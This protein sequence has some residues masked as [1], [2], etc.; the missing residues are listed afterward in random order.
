MRINY[1][2]HLQRKPKEDL[3]SPERQREY[4][5]LLKKIEAQTEK[6]EKM[7]AALLPSRSETHELYAVVAFESTIFQ[8]I[9]EIQKEAAEIE[10][11]IQEL[12][13]PQERELMRL[14]YIDGMTWED[15]SDELELSRQWTVVL[16]NKILTKLSKRYLQ[17]EA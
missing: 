2:S 8:S 1:V 5:K 6:V 14:R 12:E 10:R 3:I 7:K 16:N 4:L 13:S 15:V 11:K 9:I 17:G